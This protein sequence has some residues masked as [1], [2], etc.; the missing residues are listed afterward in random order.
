MVADTLESLRPKLKL[1]NSLE[2]AM[3]AVEELNLEYQQKI[4]NDSGC[5]YNVSS[6]FYNVKKV[7]ISF[8]QKMDIEFVI[9]L[10]SQMRL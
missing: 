10:Y 3:K 1:H 7:L 4:G 6:D 2:E 5:W 9:F 8:N